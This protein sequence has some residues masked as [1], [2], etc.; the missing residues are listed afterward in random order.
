MFN[1]LL[2]KRQEEDINITY[3]SDYKTI[4]ILF[5]PIDNQLITKLSDKIDLEN[6]IHEN[7]DTNIFLIHS[8]VDNISTESNDSIAFEFDISALHNKIYNHRAT[9][10]NN[11]FSKQKS[12]K[13][14]KEND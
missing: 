1:Y 5:Q 4:S 14:Q 7:N 3:N 9:A 6:I 12:L 10:L 2:E 11:Y 13:V 8:L